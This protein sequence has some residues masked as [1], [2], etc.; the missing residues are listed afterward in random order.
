[1][2]QVHGS[3]HRCNNLNKNANQMYYVLKSLKILFTLFRSTCFGHH[4]VHQQE[5]LSCTCSLWSR[6]SWWWTQWC[7]KHVERNNV[8]KILRILKQVHLV[9]V[10]IQI[11]KCC[12][13][14][15]LTDRGLAG[16]EHESTLRIQFF[17]WS[18]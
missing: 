7:P 6:S 17:W 10:F 3:V 15:F 12:L 5:L 18:A 13:C 2:F 4:C 16:F 9:G 8:N 11:N 1:M 14:L